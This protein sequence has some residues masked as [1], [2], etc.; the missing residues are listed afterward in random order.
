MKLSKCK[1]SV[2]MVDFLGF[3]LGTEGIAMEQSQVQT[4][5]EWPEPMTFHEVQV[6]L[7]FVNFYFRFI[8]GYSR[9]VGPL[10]TML[11]ESKDSKKTGPYDMTPEART[12]FRKLK[13]AFVTAPVL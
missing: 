8:A 3:I 9:I 11:Q 6:F 12:A 10:T 7:G 5:Q 13:A 2:D 4:I 1:F